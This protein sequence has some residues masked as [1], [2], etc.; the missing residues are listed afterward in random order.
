MLAACYHTREL[1]HAQDSHQW[2]VADQSAW[3][4]LYGCTAGLVG[5]GSN[6]KMLAN[7]LLAL[8]MRLI[9]WDRTYQEGFDDVEQ[10]LSSDPDSLTD[11]VSRSD[12]I[13]LNLALTDQTYHLFDRALFAHVKP[14]AVLVNMARGALVDTSALMDAL[15]RGILS[16]AGLDVFEQEPL[17]ADHPLW[18]YKNVYIT[19]HVTPQV[20]DRTGKLHR[21]I[22]RECAPLP[23]RG[24]PSEPGGSQG[25]LSCAIERLEGIHDG[26]RNAGSCLIPISNTRIIPL[27]CGRTVSYADRAAAQNQRRYAASCRADPRH[28]KACRPARRFLPGSSR[29][30]PWARGQKRPAH[31]GAGHSRHVG[32]QYSLDDEAQAKLIYY[33]EHH[34][35]HI[36][37]DADA[38]LAAGKDTDPALYRNLL[39][40][41]IAD[42][43][44]HVPVSL[45]L[46]RI[47]ACRKA[48]FLYVETSIPKNVA[49][50]RQK[51]Q[52]AEVKMCY[53]VRCKKRKL[54]I[55][56]PQ[57]AH[58]SPQLVT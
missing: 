21:D 23:R 41:K 32:P 2:G 57:L 47:D 19:P 13:C 24:T 37:M 18:D 50:C 17:P 48:L 43:I 28:R 56:S 25:C 39:Y 20:P 12:F 7:R 53:H 46:Q 30:A 16:C 27:I 9:S 51:S 5:M 58:S 3:R 45:M 8:G 26:S 54:S 4:G 36:G 14:G 44:A 10:L 55:T 6:G 29:H 11:L 33:A 52:D 31:S 15:D 42:S 40:L 38:I 49:A 35:D 22:E 34:D 1:L